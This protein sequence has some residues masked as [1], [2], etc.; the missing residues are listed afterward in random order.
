VE[1]ARDGKPV[2]VAEA[3]ENMD[4]L[5]GKRLEELR[6]IRREAT[7]A[8]ITGAKSQPEYKIAKPRISLGKKELADQSDDKLAGWISEIV[9]VE[10]PVHLGAVYSRF[11]AAAKKRPG[12]RNKQAFEKGLEQAVVKR[13]CMTCGTLDYT[14]HATNCGVCD[15]DIWSNVADRPVRREGDF[16]ID[17]AQETV[18][19]RDRRRLSASD[20]KFELVADVELDAATLLAV[21]QSYGIE[22]E[23][24]SIAATRLLGF[25]RTLE[26]M[27][28]RVDERVAAMLA[29]GR[30]IERE[31]QIHEPD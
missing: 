25:E 15:N 30:L 14:G 7:S 11:L 26:Q 31:E 3:S 1:A 23:D 12:A 17:A 2:A 29:E 9:Q 10:S 24:I 28:Q 22:V 19:I 27:R 16:L 8:K 20:R 6:T 4:R 21:G 18:T 5:R 13:K